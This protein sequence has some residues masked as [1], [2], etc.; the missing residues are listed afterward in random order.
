[1]VVA[2][3][4]CNFALKAALAQSYGAVEVIITSDELVSYAR[5]TMSM[6]QLLWL[7]GVTVTLP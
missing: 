3:G 2:R 1:M 5:V 4:D 7:L 6:V